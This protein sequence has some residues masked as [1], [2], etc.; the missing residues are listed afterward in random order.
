MD[1]IYLINNGL[2]CFDIYDRLLQL[3][4]RKKKDGI[5]INRKE[6][7]SLRKIRKNNSDKLSMNGIIE[8]RQL[9]NSSEFRSLVKGNFNANHFTYRNQF[10][11]Y[12]LCDRVSIETALILLN[13]ENKNEVGYLELIIL[14]YIKY[15]NSIKKE[16]DLTVFK[17]SFG[18]N[19]ASNLKNYWNIESNIISFKKAIKINWS[20]VDGISFEDLKGYK[21][22]NLVDL[23]IRSKLHYGYNIHAFIIC[24]TEMIK[25]LFKLLIKEKKYIP[26]AHM[27]IFNTH[28]F[29]LDFSRRGTMLYFNELSTIYPS[30]LGSNNIKYTFE[31]QKYDL[32][33]Q[34]Y[35]K[36][37]LV[38]KLNIIPKSRC[39][40][41]DKL[42]KIVNTIKMG[43]NKNSSVKSKKNNINNVQDFEDIFNKI[44]K[45]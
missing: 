45:N 34:Y 33:F 17:N 35:S 9:R 30:K 16:N 23:L 8:T 19:V 13:K 7:V 21:L 15:E 43:K 1:S 26:D 22:T 29:K 11:Y 40:D 28:C 3:S 12:C 5:Q 38:N 4:R 10:K 27:K 6:L 2:T 24:N 25:N 31:G 42:I 44:N 41:S 36:R 32:Y 37:L 20:L 39:F 14:P 18:K